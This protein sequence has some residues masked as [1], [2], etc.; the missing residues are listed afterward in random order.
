MEYSV[1]ATHTTTGE[2][3]RTRSDEDDEKEFVT[4]FDP[5]P[6]MEDSEDDDIGGSYIRYEEFG[7]HRYI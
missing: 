5:Y 6:D 4:Q 7:G 1:L 2:I 3:D